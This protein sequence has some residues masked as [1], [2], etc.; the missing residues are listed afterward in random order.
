MTS[1]AVSDSSAKLNISI[2]AEND[3]NQS[4]NPRLEFETQVF[5]IGPDGKAADRVAA[6]FA[7]VGGEFPTTTVSA[8]G[9]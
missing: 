1:D 6:S 2:T 5:E 4:G 9:R 7:S 3:G 8:N